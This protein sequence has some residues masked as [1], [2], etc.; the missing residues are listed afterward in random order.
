MLIHLVRNAVFWLNAFPTNDG[1][2]KKYS[3]RYIL[4]GQ[5]L[6]YKKHAV[7]EFGA[8][9]Q[10]HEQHSNNME[11]RTMG[12][13]CLGPTGNQQG[14]HWFMSLSSGERVTR[15]R[16]TELPIPKEVI[17]RVS[18]IGRR[19]GMPSTITYA[20]RHGREIGETIADYQAVED[21]DSDDESYEDSYQSDD[22]DSDGSSGS[23]NSDNGSSDNPDDNSSS[24]SS[25][26]DDDADD[27]DHG[28]NE[29]GIIP[30]LRQIHD[31]QQVIQPDEH[32]QMDE[33]EGVSEN[34]DENQGVNGP[35]V[36]RSNSGVG[37]QSDTDDSDNDDSHYEDNEHAARP[38]EYERFQAAEAD[39]RAR[40]QQQSTK[41]TRRTTRSTQ[42]HAFVQSIVGSLLKSIRNSNDS[43]VTTQMSAKAGLQRFGQR[44]SEAVV[45][46]LRQLLLMNVM[47]GCLPNTL[48]RKQKR[49]ALKYLMFLKEKRNGTIKGRGCADGRKQRLYK[50]K[51]ETSSPTVSI[52]SLILSCLIDALEKR[53]VATCDIPGAFMQADVDEEIHIKFDGELVDLLI[54][55]DSSYAQY[56]VYEGQNKVIYAI[57]NKA[58]Y[59]TVQASLLF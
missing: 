12:A 18:A 51:A 41:R 14:G 3:P 39:G 13:I 34:D 38:T 57:L 10:T 54:S 42:N 47:N 33:N 23:D 52:E 50:T 49:K 11:Q 2:S 40:A 43:F 37:D 35:D 48:T 17:D 4:T 53:D 22:E 56:V 29:M 30:S 8:Y 24:D 21:T 46:E 27:G 58:L 44:G 6:S 31:R 5:Q 32:S 55:V 9:V 16:W 15:Y 19:Q 20:D 25:S 26:D 28:D 45:K 59:G 7:I 1:V 36:V